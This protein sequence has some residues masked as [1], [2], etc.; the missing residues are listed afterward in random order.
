MKSGK[1]HVSII[2]REFNIESENV[3]E[4]NAMGRLLAKKM[5][6]DFKPA[7]K[8]AQQGVSTDIEAIG[9]PKKTDSIAAVFVNFMKQLMLNMLP[10]RHSNKKLTTPK[11]PKPATSTTFFTSK[12]NWTLSNAKE[13]PAKRREAEVKISDAKHA[14]FLTSHPNDSTLSSDMK[15][16]TESII[17]STLT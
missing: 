10:W 16:A 4:A 12:D 15:K 13:K 14:A 5:G 7:A 2:S 11:E 6:L 8:K 1:P 17:P 3:Q 9:A